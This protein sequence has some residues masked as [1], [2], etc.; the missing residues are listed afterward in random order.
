VVTVTGGHNTRVP[1][2]ALITHPSRLIY[3][4]R[5]HLGGRRDG[6]RKGL[7][8]TDTPACWM[9]RTSSSM[10]PSSW[11]GTTS[12]QVLT[13]INKASPGCALA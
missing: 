5:T 12:R 11:S 10:V 2:A 7:I 3:I 13:K 4:A 6:R 9:S 8:E 1:L